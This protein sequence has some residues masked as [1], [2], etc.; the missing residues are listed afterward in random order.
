VDAGIVNCPVT[1]AAVVLLLVVELGAM[2]GV[3]TRIRLRRRQR[4]CD[5][6]RP[7]E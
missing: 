3:T 5:S 4:D 7:P 2:A 6:D 1:L